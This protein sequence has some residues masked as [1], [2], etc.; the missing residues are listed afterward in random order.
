MKALGFAALALM[1]AGVAPPAGAAPSDYAKVVADAQRLPANV[2]MDEGRMPAAVL[3]FAGFKAGDV[4]ADYQ[5]GG[6]YYSELLSRVVGPKGRVY[7]LT[8]PNMY[9]AE[10]WTALSARFPNVVPL[11]AP[12]TGLML[13]PGSVD[14]VFAHLVYHDLYWESAKYQHPWM[15]PSVVAANWFAAV[16]PG[17]RVVIVDHAGPAGDTRA[18]VEKFHRIDPAIVRRDMEQA[19]F[20]FEASSDVLHRSDDPHTANVFDP[21]IRG[22][23]DR[24]VLK[25]RKPG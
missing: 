20:V 18:V 15:D 1:A 21:S 13:A 16:K 14:G 17:G 4:I 2:A 19:G 7:A 10:A 22:K 3:D 12:A 23:T 5:A 9:K 11:V 24:F 25:F 6:G 8:Q